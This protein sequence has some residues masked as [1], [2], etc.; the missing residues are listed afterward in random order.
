MDHTHTH[1]WTYTHRPELLPVDVLLLLPWC[2]MAVSFQIPFHT[3]STCLITAFQMTYE[4]WSWLVSGVTLCQCPP[5]SH[6]S[7]RCKPPPLPN[8]TR[9]GTERSKQTHLIIWSRDKT[10][11]KDYSYLGS[12]A[13]YMWIACEW[14][15]ITVMQITYCKCWSRGW[16]GQKNCERFQQIW[17]LFYFRQ[18]NFT[19]VIML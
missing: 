1:T 3:V 8:L 4:P 16:K 18:C 15:Q 14:E 2:L 13:N 11:A 5:P 12:E 6:T 19:V 7:H 10:P 9:W 17:T